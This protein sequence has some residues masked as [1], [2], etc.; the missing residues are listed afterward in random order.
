MVEDYEI[1]GLEEKLAASLQGEVK[2]D[3]GYR[4]LYATDSSNYRQMP[5]GVVFPKDKDDIVKTVALCNEY[6]VPVLC[7][8][9]GTSLA[10]Q[11]C[12]VAVILDFSKYYN[13]ILDFNV[14]EHTV[15]VEPGIVLDDLR[16]EI[17][18]QGFTFGPDP[19]THN[20]CTLGGM[21]G[22]NSCG[23]HSVMAAWEGDGARTADFVEE[24][25]VLTYD[26]DIFSVGRATQDELQQIINKGGAKGNIYSRLKE[27][28]EKYAELIRLKYPKIPR[29][30]SGYNLD[31]LLP[32]RSFNVARSL[33]G[34]ESTCVV[35]LSAKLKLIHFFKERALVVLGYKDVYESARHINEILAFK[36]IG[37]EG[38]DDKLISFMHKKH[39]HEDILTQLPEG[40]GW[41][42]AEFG[43]DTKEDAAAK[44]YSLMDAL[45][46]A[47]EKPSMKIF[48]TSD[49]QKRIWKVRDS[50]L[51][52]TAFVPGLPDA[53]EGWEDS[54]VPPENLSE[55]LRAF[56]ELL[57]KYHYDT[58]LYGH[59][60]QGCVHCRI[61]FDFRTKEGIDIYK[62]FTDEASDL[63]LSFGGSL[64]GEHG[65]GQS[66][67]DL[68]EK[69]FGAELFNAFREFKSAWDPQW[70]MNPGKV[71]DAYPRDTNLRLGAHH[72]FKETESYFG[73]PAEN[74]SFGRAVL[75]CVGVGECRKTDA[76]TMC[77]SYMVTRDEK[78]STRGRAHL[79]FEMMKG[80]TITELWKSEDVKQ[81]LD[82]CLACKGC[83]SECPVNVDVATYKAEYFAHYY[84]NKIRPR[85]AYAFGMIDQWAKI[86]SAFPGAVN[87][88]TQSSVFKTF[89]KYIAGIAPEREVPRFARKTFTGQKR[90]S[91]A[92]G[93]KVFLWAD[94]F[95]N[96]FFPLT[97]NAAFDVLQSAGFEIITYEKPLCCGRPLY[98]FGMLDRA[99]EKLVQVMNE[100]RQYLQ[101]GIPI[102]GLEPSCVS[103]FRNELLNLFPNDESAGALAK[104]FFT[105]A[106]FI[107][108]YKKE[109]HFKALSNKALYHGH[110][111]H[112]AV[113]QIE[114]DKWLIDNIGLECEFPDAGCCG[115][116]GSFGFERGEKYNIS[117]QIGERVLLPAI[118]K[119]N[120]D[121]LIIADGF[122]CREQIFH[123]TGRKALHLAEV[124]KMAI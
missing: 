2:F 57:N 3:I 85:S 73:F 53:W 68:L 23:V 37:L 110:C 100:L 49:E 22:N 95:N 107:E 43:G 12:N 33:S 62:V 17:E 103:V 80:E 82:L 42:W 14:N 16:R 27:I 118:R 122:S 70:K 72:H 79:L 91:A 26:G 38:V 24:L 81:S 106:E 36:P 102:V 10:G 32:E 20:H 52:A 58:T 44:A 39:L 25:E 56:R 40:N 67:A 65:D 117:I 50:G 105:L 104:N 99:K 11:C 63:V 123:G 5:I 48:L 109:F 89:S 6:K 78:H 54:A 93:K 9:G 87:F 96:Y 114:K 55:Y 97:L 47:D 69:M 4:A 30:V 51:G 31:E 83:L 7:R 34:T 86:A 46:K 71:I 119:T 8:G 98:D 18:P 19:A 121:T 29:R 66:R 1:N 28:S 108:L 61:N 124:L 13:R 84:K 75:R 59:F 116:A 92:G 15:T 76:G 35:I 21:I 64:S 115:L 74:G 112:K 45:Q 111:H 94:T 90:K 113:M 101:Q 41:L 77:P 120:E 88:F 60:G